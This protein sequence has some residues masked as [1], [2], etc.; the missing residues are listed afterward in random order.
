[1]GCHLLRPEKCVD[2][3]ARRRR[4]PRPCRTPRE[5]E[6]RARRDR[7]V[8][9][10]SHRR[11]PAPRDN[12]AVDRRT[13]R[14]RQ[15]A[16]GGRIS[17]FVIRTEKRRAIDAE[18]NPLFKPRRTQLMAVTWGTGR[19]RAEGVVLGGHRLCPGWLQPRCDWP[20]PAR[21]RRA[22]VHRERSVPPRR[23]LVLRRKSESYSP[24]L[25]AAG[26]SA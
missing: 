2:H 25:P 14:T 18:G 10:G 16:T 26:E 5:R 15:C 21:T 6:R 20:L 4:R 7:A 17:P 9:P 3:R 1:M 11:Q 19:S 23:R 13:I 8:R 22:D 24:A 12:G